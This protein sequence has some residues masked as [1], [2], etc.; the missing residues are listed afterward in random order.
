MQRLK[1]IERMQKDLDFLYST[2]RDG[3][4]REAISFVETIIDNWFDAELKFESKEMS[5]DE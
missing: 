2:A 4:E 1:L 5:D 3:G